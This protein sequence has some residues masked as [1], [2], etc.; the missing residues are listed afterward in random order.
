M[1]KRIVSMLLCLLMVVGAVAPSV[2]ATQTVSYGNGLSADDIYFGEGANVVYNSDGSFTVNSS[3][4]SDKETSSSVQAQTPAVPE[5][6][7]QASATV[8]ETTVDALGVPKDSSLTVAAPKA[9]A[10]PI[11]DK[12]VAKH[13]G[14][15]SELFRYDI[16]VQDKA[17]LDWQPNG[18]VRL[19]MDAGRKLHKNEKVYVV[20][21]SDDG[22]ANYI[23]AQVNEAGKIV[24]E[25]NGFSTF[26]GFTVDFE[27]ENAKFS[28][29]G[30]S[31]ILLSDV[32]NRLGMPLDVE[33]VMNVEFSDY[34]LISLEKQGNDWLLTSLEA[35]QTTEALVLTMNDGKVYEI[36]V[37][38]AI[39][40]KANFYAAYYSGGAYQYIDG[41][42]TGGNAVVQLFLDSDGYPQSND[43]AVDDMG[44]FDTQPLVID[45][46][47]VGGCMEIVLQKESGAGN[48]LVWDLV[49]L[50]ITGGAKVIIRLGATFSGTETIT[51]N[52]VRPYTNAAR[53]LFNIEDGSLYFNLDSNDSGLVT[54]TGADIQSTSSVKQIIFDG[55]DL[56]ASASVPLIYHHRGVDEADR[57]NLVI[58]G[59]TFRDAKHRAVLV[60]TNNMNNL[61]F[62]NCTFESTVRDVQ[63][64]GGAIYIDGGTDGSTSNVVDVAKFGLYNC[65]FSGNTGASGHGG[66]IACYGD[67]HTLDID[68]CTFQNCTSAGRAG[69]IEFSVNTKTQDNYIYNWFRIRNTTFTDCTAATHG[70]AIDISNNDDPLHLAAGITIDGCTFTDC[71][72]NGNRS[73]AIRMVVDNNKNLT[74]TNSGFSGC[75]ANTVGG[76]ISVQGT[77]GAVSISGSKTDA[78]TGEAYTFRK[79]TSQEHGGAITIN[80]SSCSSLTLTGAKFI[81][82]KSGL[83]TASNPDATYH[84]GGIYVTGT[85]GN[86]T[87][88][89][90]TDG[91]AKTVFSGCEATA[92][93]GAIAIMCG[94]VGNI[95]LSSSEFLNCIAGS[96]GGGFHVGI[97]G[98][99]TTMPTIGAVSVTDCNFDGNEAGGVGGG[100]S[101][102][103][104]TY[105][106]ITVKTSSFA[107][108]FSANY[109]G[110]IGMKVYKDAEA[111]AR[112][113][114]VTG[115]V[116]I[117]D[118]TFS[119]CSAGALSPEP[120]DTDGDGVGDKTTWDHDGDPSTAELIRLNGGGGGGAIAI[121]GEVG[122]S[123]TIKDTTKDPAIEFD[124][125]YTWNNGGALCFIG[126]IKTPLINIENVDIDACR[127]RDAG[128]AIHL[129]NLIAND[130][131]MTNCDLTNNKYFTR[132]NTAASA[133]GFTSTLAL[134]KDPYF[135][136]YGTAVYA[137]YDAGGTFRSVGNTTCRAVISGCHFEGNLSY[138]NGAG[139][140][141]NA[142]NIRNGA[143]VTKDGVTTTPEIK[144]SLQ[145]IGSTFKDNIAER[146]GGGV[147]VEATVDIDDCDFE[148]N[149]AWGRGG[150][151]AQQ[152]YS[153]E[154]RELGEGEA[155]NLIL[156]KD[157]EIWNNHAVHGGGISITV[158][159]T[160]SLVPTI[161]LVEGGEPVLYMNYPVKFQL[162]GATVRDNYASG[163]GGGIYYATTSYADEAIQKKVDTFQKEVLIDNGKIYGNKTGCDATGT[164]YTSKQQDTQNG[165]GI[166][167]YSNQPHTGTD[168]VTSQVYGYSNMTITGGN[169]YSNE[170]NI[171]DGGGIY[172]TGKGAS[173][174]ITGGTIGADAN[175]TA[176]PNLAKRVSPN[177][178]SG[179]GIA[180][181][182][183]ATITMRRPWL[184]NEKGEWLDKEGNVTTDESKC[185]EDP[186]A[187]G[188][189]VVNNI[190]DYQ[191]AGIWL[192]GKLTDE[193]GNYIEGTNNTINISGGTISGNKN[194]GTYATNRNGGGIYVGTYGT[195]SFTGGT[196]SNCTAN[197]WGGGVFLDS[198]AEAI[199][200]GGTITGCQAGAGGG[201]AIQGLGYLEFKNG[202]IHNNTAT[203]DGNAGGG[204]Y[205]NGTSGTADNHTTIII[206]GGNV[207]GNHATSTAEGGGHGGGIAGMKYT[208][209]TISSGSV[210][211]NDATGNGGGL[212]LYDH[213][214]LK[215][216]GGNIGSATSGLGNEAENGGGVYADNSEVLLEKTADANTGNVIGNSAISMAEDGGC[217]GGVYATNGATITVNGDVKSN[218][219][220]RGGGI[221]GNG[222]AQIEVNGNLYLNKV[223]VGNVDSEGGGAAIYESGTKLT[224]TGNI[225]AENNGNWAYGRG[226][227][228][229][230]DN[231]TLELKSVGGSVGQIAHNTAQNGQGGG[232][233][234]VKATVT[235]GG[236]VTNNHAPGTQY[237]KGGGIHAI[238]G[239]TVTI[240]GSLSNNDSGTQGGGVH[241]TGSTVNV[242][243]NVNSNTSLTGGGI[244]AMSNSTILVE[245][246]TINDNTANDWGGGAYI[247]ASKLTLKK[248]SSG[249]G[250]LISGN[251]ALD[252][253]GGGIDA[254]DGSTIE[255]FGDVKS[256][257]ASGTGDHG[258]GGGINAIGSGTTVT[259][260]G[261]V[262]GNEAPLGGGVAASTSAKITVYGQII[263]NTASTGGGG[264][265][266]EGSTLELLK[267]EAGNPGLISGNTAVA[268]DGGGIYASNSTLTIEGN[269]TSNTANKNGGGIKA[270]TN[271]VITVDGNITG[272][273]A[274][275][276]DGG[277]IYAYSITSLTIGGN[278]TGN[279]ATAGNGG[280]VYQSGG[281]LIVNGTIGGSTANANKAP[282]G[283]GGGLYVSSSCQATVNGSVTYNQALNGAGA[284]VAG[285]ATLNINGHLDNNTATGNGG[286]AY[287]NSAT[288]N[289]N[290][291]GTTDGTVD[292]NT[293]ATN[294]GGIY[295]KSSSTVKVDGH[296]YSNKANGTADGSGGG[297]AY[298]NSSSLTLNG[299]IGAN[300]K[301]NTA[302]FYGGGAYVTNGGTATIDGT[303]QYNTA[304]NGGG[305]MVGYNSDVEITG[306]VI[307]NNASVS[308]G[309]IYA[310]QATISL[311]GNL[312]SNKATSQD[313]GGIYASGSTLTIND[314]NIDGNTAYR[315]GG[316]V[317]AQ[318]KSEITVNGDVVNNVATTGNGGGLHIHNS[319]EATISGGNIQG[320][321]AQATTEGNG[322]GG[323]VHAYQNSTVTITGGDIKENL[324]NTGG[325]VSA[326]N[327]STIIISD[328]NVDQNT[329]AVSGGGVLLLSS[330]SLTISN[331]SIT[332]NKANTYGGGG[333]YAV[334]SSLTLQNGNIE[335]NT[336]EQ[337]GGGVY[338]EGTATTEGVV[339]IENGNIK[340]NVATERNGG[341]LL[342]SSYGKITI[343]GGTIQANKATKGYGG[344]VHA[345]NGGSV[346]ISGGSI[347]QNEA[348]RGGGI[349]AE[350]NAYVEFTNVVSMTD[351]GGNLSENTA[352]EYGGGIYAESS[353]VKVSGGTIEK[354]T[355]RYGG[356]IA[357]VSELTVGPSGQV[358]TLADVASAVTVEGGAISNNY[359]ENGGGIFA[360]DENTKV[361]VR[362]GNIINNQARSDYANPNLT[363]KAADGSGGGIYVDNAVVEVNKPAGSDTAGMVKA[364]HAARGGG[365]YVINGGDLTVKGGYIVENRAHGNE[366]VT[367]ADDWYKKSD[368]LGT[369]GG[370]FVGD[371]TDTK[372]STFTLVA[373]ENVN[374]EVVKI[375]VAIHSNLADFAADDVFAS[376]INTDLNVPLV[377]QMD[378]AGYPFQPGGWFEDYA[379]NDVNYS[380]GLS[381]STTDLVTDG[382]VH[383]YRGSAVVFRIEIAPT[384]L[385]D[386][387][388]L[389][390]NVENTFVCMTLGIP[391]AVGEE[392]V[393]D[394]GL[395]VDLDLLNNDLVIKDNFYLTSNLLL[396]TVH[397]F[398]T[399]AEGNKIPYDYQ[400]LDGKAPDGFSDTL[401]G[402]YG[403]LTITY[404]THTETVGDTTYEVKDYIVTYKLRD[405]QFIGV[406]SF[407][408]AVC[409]EGIW[410][411]AD[412]NI[413]PATII[414]FEENYVDFSAGVWNTVPEG[415]TS[416]TVT[417]DGDRPGV[418]LEDA[419][420]E[421]DMDNVYGYDSHYVKS[422]KYSLGVAKMTTVDAKNQQS[423]VA[424][425]TFW[426]TGFD[427][428]SL[429]SNK[430][431]AIMVT[432]KR[433]DK[434]ED[435]RYLMVDTYYSY[436]YDETTNQW[437]LSS[438]SDDNATYQVP[439]MRV[440]DLA[441]GQYW[442]EIFVGYEQYIFD[443]GQYGGGK[444]DFYLDAIRIYNPANNGAVIQKDSNGNPVKDS[445]GNLVL[446]ADSTIQ[447]AYNED[448]EYA[449]VI[450]ELRN[451]IL[452][453]AKADASKVTGVLFIDR[454]GSASTVADYKAYGPNNELYLDKDQS[455]SFAITNSASLAKVQLAMKAL[456][457][458]VKVRITNTADA[459]E[460]KELTITS[461][462]DLY[463]D[464]SNFIGDTI[465]IQNVSDSKGALLSI[466]NKKVTYKLDTGAAAM[467]G[468]DFVVDGDTANNALML[469]NGTLANPEISTT[470]ASLS[471][472]D[473]VKYNVY[474]T[475][476][477]PADIVEMGLILFGQRLE[478]GT[479]S[480][481][482][483]VIPGYVTN[484]TEYMVSTNGIPA[485]QMGD[486][487][488]FKVYAKLSDGSFAYSDVAGYS[489]ATYAKNIL[490]KE[491]ASAESKALVVA[492]MNYGTEAQKYFGYKTEALMNS[493]LTAEQQALV[494][495]YDASSI[496]SPYAADSSKV[497]AFTAT[498]GFSGF[499]TSVSF[500]GAFAIN[501][502]VTPAAEATVTMYYWKQAD[503]EAAEVLTAENATGTMTMTGAGE[504]FAAVSGIAAKEMEDTVFVAMVY[505][506]DDVTYSTGVRAYSLAAYCKNIAAKEDSAM[507]AL[508]QATAIYGSYAKAYFA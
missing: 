465:V 450:E 137:A 405:M 324:A 504:V 259:I 484:G 97:A 129:S 225:G 233:K 180:I 220:I 113:F 216:S 317:Y 322:Y 427:I 430:T 240:N 302:S 325:G 228:V 286:G 473:E 375:P 217:G 475:V 151:I 408:Y 190:A 158:S 94:T 497:G 493:F 124:H 78:T 242:Y 382:K 283:Y 109:G 467:D 417:Q 505:E 114:K 86:V 385:A 476:G 227:G 379:I 53:P 9:E 438:Q 275:T 155:T 150:A 481:A 357:A 372:E 377:T 182:G 218:T 451:L 458:E 101:L 34:S 1:M 136:E 236:N 177:G 337:F 174:L 106:S 75:T 3:G 272:N 26:A 348:K 138:Q 479:I 201:V 27:Y 184:T 332:N 264:A 149:E 362:G 394:F 330:S 399:D 104:G 107:N 270:D 491:D 63:Y 507:Q 303:I 354:N 186:D 200:D 327:G 410:Y 154:A 353:T 214:Y 351:D 250:G 298:I 133:G 374:G 254:E 462:T 340:S 343:S 345:Y 276:L 13:D 244:Y 121:G 335:M 474:Y 135:V 352:T 226:G 289:V 105:K 434:T 295:A 506:V 55:N 145:I 496:A 267:D 6:V 22:K 194:S 52:S 279:T 130:L 98:S 415:A 426:G 361:V 37:T 273:T 100:L 407:T 396:G 193:N 436:T 175:G 288:L 268:Y 412:V 419:L 192:A 103:E 84:G 282:Q 312:K 269:I 413:I 36:K 358:I 347:T 359:A 391:G 441:Y 448:G 73:G 320:N 156:D 290:K 306:N 323:G 161:P 409:Y 433:L 309:G 160:I 229:L 498:E 8:G 495:A 12:M 469:L 366:G 463:Y 318:S 219:A 178:G 164:A 116:L 435:E 95:S 284:A 203:N 248:D 274:K 162:G 342:A 11:I 77:I 189:F 126:T 125:C 440:D 212:Y 364:N 331:G 455:I 122:T 383:R 185:V 17:G 243:G 329:A 82:N 202:N 480:N 304:K 305:I 468:G 280:G 378:L 230:V 88:Q 406:E 459:N 112:P 238:S 447:N 300:G 384:N 60:Q 368:M 41:Y 10:E 251:K 253:N 173:C 363:D 30:L 169:I 278:I 296:M 349:A 38:D 501:Y 502:Y 29:W 249:N 89:S 142:N 66:A 262:D 14:A 376:G 486:V 266:I 401:K 255:I 234:A 428:V 404:T 51:I 418:D 120:L 316:G 483:M 65:T 181:H 128:N 198:H 271:C 163:N 398:Q 76:A 470:G 43:S 452:D 392:I 403:D 381:G 223:G 365:V 241:A 32:F 179:G 252:G 123:I 4:K 494:A 148:S 293:A 416:S 389:P 139:V 47:G 386:A 239:S 449:P 338:V 369:G 292:G 367:G 258:Y 319:S 91:T 466:T 199:I 49:E 157:T 390:A 39:T 92:R 62:R 57:Q 422:N 346:Y 33:D 370:I 74:V 232:I 231:A 44:D 7:G 492:L 215:L 341:G 334:E 397:P 68:G 490:A 235:I 115:A 446:N 472:E 196:I 48:N 461:S 143:P 35:F 477:D 23:D 350:I 31:S 339:T 99:V 360:Q 67:V 144:P 28:I 387:G 58:R 61:I 140:Y 301:A 314:G 488:Y 281:T 500:E 464:L 277:G 204:I 356:G 159:N 45:G 310:N 71:K 206:N 499:G 207:Y 247:T 431:G 328:G 46:R 326:E 132:P 423:A 291:V 424:E 54:G 16:S 508:A 395:P 321:K 400:D 87:F 117:Q 355:A 437:R 444:Y 237:G 183:G 245:G 195:L 432:I 224:V 64:G 471:F 85:I 111:T 18:M 411:Y 152:V 79:C 443:H 256:N 171:G 119:K 90:S 25:T 102:T 2:S 344:G 141:W 503:Y 56:G 208:N 209:I 429:C 478:D 93:G 42:A 456:G 127:A 371:G 287:V 131:T 442:V 70:G 221:F 285:S 188:G 210:Y 172:L 24:F 165:G 393:L 205:D 146:D 108:C 402:V 261:T 420:G 313:G 297:G 222:K 69:A 425:F 257:T 246:G 457:D 260:N 263:N 19:E 20:H 15:S 439:V 315:Y 72:A 453:S 21:V 168:A 80:T 489:A 81:G 187:D 485:K 50:K 166:Y 134:M 153:N 110:G 197:G 294:G 83:K 211:D 176:A 170:A 308:G 5:E 96:L 333:V 307:N 421:L 482:D 118:C 147:Y 373:F 460:K 265:H 454:F 213:S 191:G 336:A 445:S 414:Y 59:V 487:I 299:T 311:A 380:E 167:M 388:S 40:T